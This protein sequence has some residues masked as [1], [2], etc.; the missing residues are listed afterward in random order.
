[1]IPLVVAIVALVA[2][3]VIAIVATRSVSS[4]EELQSD[5]GPGRNELADRSNRMRA[6]LRRRRGGPRRRGLEEDEEEEEEEPRPEEEQQKPVSRRDAYE[7]RR[8]AKDAE[9]EAQEEAQRAEMLRV[10]QEREAKEQEEAEKWMH[11]FTMQ[12]A[13]EEAISKEDGEE[14][15]NNMVEYIK[16]KKM[17]PLEDMAAQFGIRTADVI[18]K[19]KQLEGDKRITGIMDDRG[20][21]IYISDEEMKSVAAFI[22]QRG[23]IGISELAKESAGLIDLQQ[24]DDTVDLNI[25]LDDL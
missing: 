16:T 15:L 23:R 14:L 25:E 24:K 9:R 10:A 1:M 17:V 13:G 12:E 19:V 4:Q 22:K 21:Y 18:E 11:M 2:L 3:V 5:Q 7:Q 20:K 6:G 8:A